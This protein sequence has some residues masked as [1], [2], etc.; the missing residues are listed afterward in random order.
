MVNPS[1]FNAFIKMA[2]RSA[3]EIC[4]A[5]LDRTAVHGEVM[6]VGW[7]CGF[8]PRD[9]FDYTTGSSHIPLD[10]LTDTDRRWLSNSV[11]GGFGTRERI[12]GGVII[13]EPN[14]E[15]VSADGREA[16][17]KKSRTTGAVGGTPVAGGRGGRGG[18]GGGGAGSASASTSNSGPGRGRGRGGPMTTDQQDAAGGPRGRGMGGRGRGLEE[19]AEQQ[20]Q[21]QQQHWSHPLPHRPQTTPTGFQGQQG[22]TGSGATWGGKRDLGQ[23]QDQ[24]IGGAFQQQG[25]EEEPR[26]SKKSRWE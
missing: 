23:N 1:K 10:R 21:Q 11:V 5:D 20:Q 18:V 15:P 16:L 7:G 25:Q 19:H 8:G 6:K 3:A 13:L 12:R 22:Q 26:R 14:I 9:C 24:A 4:K 17:P 2:D